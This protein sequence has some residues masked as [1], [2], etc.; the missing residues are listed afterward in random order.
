[1]KKEELIEKLHEEFGYC[2]HCGKRECLG[3]KSY[4]K[5]PITLNT[6]TVLKIIE[7]L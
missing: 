6:D 2:G 3:R 4:S 5:L 1:M 7:Q